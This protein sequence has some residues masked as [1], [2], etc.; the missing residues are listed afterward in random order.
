LPYAAGIPGSI[1]FIYI[2]HNGGILASEPPTILGLESDTVYRAYYWEPSLGIKVELGT[3]ERKSPGKVIAADNFEG[4]DERWSVLLGAGFSH[5]GRLR[6]E[7]KHL[8]LFDGI[9]EKDLVAEVEISSRSDAALVLRYQDD[10][11]YIEAYYDASR[12]HIYFKRHKD[13]ISQQIGSGISVELLGL[14]ARLITEIRGKWGVISLTDGKTTYTT[15]ITDIGDSPIGR[16]GLSYS[17]NGMAQRFDNF[18]L[19]QSSLSDPG[20]EVDRKL[21]DAAGKYRGEMVGP[22]LVIGGAFGTLP[23]WSDY[24]KQTIVLLDAYR[25]E[26]LPTPQDWLLVLDATE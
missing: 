3:V 10:N 13:G 22:G 24:G 16:F 2:P 8:S 18:K 12:Q 15:P 19:R 21:Y 5:E 1:R 25:P 17:G 14:D 4:I 26:K 9:N 6:V 11:N 20:T 7:T 23:G